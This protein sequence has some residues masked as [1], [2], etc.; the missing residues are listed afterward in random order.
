MVHVIAVI[1]VRYTL[2]QKLDRCLH[3]HV[4]G[5]EDA[6]VWKLVGESLQD[7]KVDTDQLSGHRP[8]DKLCQNDFS[9]TMG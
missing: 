7:E 5:E 8:P 6:P 9:T 4:E 3:R 1:G 2:Q